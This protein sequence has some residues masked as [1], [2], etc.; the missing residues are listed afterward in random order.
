MHPLLARLD[1]WLVANRPAYHAGL[2][3]G[4]SGADIDEVAR[5][6]G[7]ELPPLLRELLT[8]RNGQNEDCDGV[9]ESLWSL[10]S[11]EDIASAMDDMAWVK[12]TQGFEDLWWGTDWVPFLANMFGDHMCIDLQGA[13]GGKP[14]QLI[15][16]RCKDE[17]RNIIYPSLD[18]WLETFVVALEAGMFEVSEQNQV[19]CL[20]PVDRGAYEAFIT[21]RH[22]GY[23]IEAC[24][25]ASPQGIRDESF[26]DFVK[27]FHKKE[28][29]H[30]VDLHKLRAALRDTGLGGKVVDGAFDRLIEMH[31]HGEITGEK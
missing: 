20:D 26:S 23:P 4:A 7:G 16:F 17:S 6:V 12:E 27:E 24:I 31:P 9:L 11:T 15:E 25:P 29:V 8:W 13:F 28:L 30:A 5:R 10:M 21:E 22:P 1:Q 3:P 14:G 19:G 2:M 18:A